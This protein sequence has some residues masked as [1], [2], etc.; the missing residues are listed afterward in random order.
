MISA[1]LLKNNLN[2]KN[3]ESDYIKINKVGDITNK[4]MSP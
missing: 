3:I 1:K 4:M 2:H